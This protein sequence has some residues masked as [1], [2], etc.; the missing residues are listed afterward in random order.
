MAKRKV[1]G[2]APEA[3]RLCTVTEARRLRAAAR[4]AALETA[5]EDAEEAIVAAAEAGLDECF[6]SM[7]P[8]PD[9]VMPML[10][11]NLMQRGSAG[12]RFVATHVLPEDDVDGTSYPYGAVR[13]SWAG[14]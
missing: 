5:I 2:G 11:D 1:T 13:V 14:P 12:E 8:Y 9:F 10:I 4:A 3:K 7:T 6:I